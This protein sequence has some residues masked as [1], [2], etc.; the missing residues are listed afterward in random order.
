M[1]CP[2]LS[3]FSKMVFHWVLVLHFPDYS[4]LVYCDPSSEKCLLVAFA[5][6]LLCCLS[7]MH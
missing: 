6:S 4:G 5:Q 3:I 7:F 2:E 1:S